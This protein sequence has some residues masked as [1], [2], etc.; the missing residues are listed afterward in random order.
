[1]LPAGADRDAGGVSGDVARDVPGDV[2][3][4][5]VGDELSSAL[6]HIDALTH[7]METLQRGMRLQQEEIARLSDGL[8]TVDGR[9]QRHEAGQEAALGLRQEIAAVRSLMDAEAELRRDL[10]ARVERSDT[11][12]TETQ[13][14]LQRVLAQVATR[15]DASEGR[16][17]SIAEREQHLSVDLAG[18]A[19][20]DQATDSRLTD[21]ER[22]ISA[23]Q[24]ATRHVGQ[25]SAHVAGIVPELLA[26]LDDLAARM[27][28][29]QEEQ[30]RLSEETAAIRA[31]RDREAG[32]LEVL[33]QQRSTRSRVDD[34][35]TALEEEIETMHRA[36][37]AIQDRLAMLTRDRAG[38]V[39]QR[40]RVE[41]RL[42]AQRD[43][44]AAHLRRVLRADE[45]RARRRVEEIERDIRIARDLLVRLD[46]QASGS[47]QEQPL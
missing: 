38:E 7:S 25:E 29:M 37:A 43:I 44:V 4:T 12:E 21:L 32:L 40:G 6:R 22:R 46:E 45:D 42:E 16:Q 33:E 14:E 2:R 47:D 26:K 27:Q 24:D 13:H 19:S 15:L 39:E 18:Q 20:V 30:R 1:M 31:V 41:E 10:V 5:W 11:R 8:Q 36:D 34:R 23:D 3:G 35:L 9:S 28:R 17:A